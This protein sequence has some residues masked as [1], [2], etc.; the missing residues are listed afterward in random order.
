MQFLRDGS[1]LATPLRQG[2]SWLKQDYTWRKLTCAESF[3][4]CD[5]LELRSKRL[6]DFPSASSG[7]TPSGRA[8]V[9]GAET[10]ELLGWQILVALVGGL[11]ALISTDTAVT[12]FSCRRSSAA[13]LFAGQPTAASLRRAHDFP[14]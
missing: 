3:P 10:P 6:S 7:T 11:T 1:Q 5:I 12:L 8:V 9:K 2:T 14:C 13:Q 4:S